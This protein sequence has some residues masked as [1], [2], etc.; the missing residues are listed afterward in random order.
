M[1]SGD[2][3]LTMGIFC[4]LR[5]IRTKI[6]GKFS[7]LFKYWMGSYGPLN[8]HETKSTIFIILCVP[9]SKIDKKK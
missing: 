2:C 1:A 9:M 8:I 5:R 4:I 6:K 3:E 7:K